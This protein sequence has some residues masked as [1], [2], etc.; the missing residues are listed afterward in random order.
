MSC[1]LSTAFKISTSDLQIYSKRKVFR[2]LQKQNVAFTVL[3]TSLP[4]LFRHVCSLD[5]ISVDRSLPGSPCNWSHLSLL[6]GHCVTASLCC[7][8]HR[9]RPPA[10]ETHNP[11]QWVSGNSH[12]W[13]IIT[14]S[15]HPNRGEFRTIFSVSKSQ[16]SFLSVS[17]QFHH[18]RYE[19]L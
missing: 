13:Y 11:W 4:F 16:N 3:D 5:I 18:L 1:I 7:H 19:G 10:S 9:P 14:S 6:P 8:A 12:N 17:S 15:F 2:K